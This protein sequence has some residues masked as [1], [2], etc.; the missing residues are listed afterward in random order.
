MKTMAASP[1]V[2][3][4]V[5][6]SRLTVATTRGIFFSLELEDQMEEDEILS[7][8]NLE[9]WFCGLEPRIL[10]KGCVLTGAGFSRESQ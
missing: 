6:K 1:G 8:R 10:R 4:S 5:I 7:L 2:C 3:T 9:Q